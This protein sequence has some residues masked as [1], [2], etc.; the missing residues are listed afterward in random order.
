MHSTYRT[1]PI[2]KPFPHGVGIIGSL[3]PLPETHDS[4]DSPVGE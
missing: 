1:A 2:G 3:S 4:H